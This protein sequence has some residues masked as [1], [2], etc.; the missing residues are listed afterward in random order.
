MEKVPNGSQ[1][2][3]T[4]VHECSAANVR[5]HVPTERRGV[6]ELEVTNCDFKLERS[7][8]RGALRPARPGSRLPFAPD[9]GVDSLPARSSGWRTISRRSSQGGTRSSELLTI[10]RRSSVTLTISGEG[11]TRACS[12][13]IRLLEGLARGEEAAEEGR[14]LSHAG[15][16]R[17]MARP[18]AIVSSA[19]SSSFAQI[20]C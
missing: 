18:G 8:E 20:R 5:L 2:K 4:C 14:T 16:E 6:R 9:I 7:S 13:R 1:S 11:L 15:A 19:I 3:A 17:R 12:H 10:G